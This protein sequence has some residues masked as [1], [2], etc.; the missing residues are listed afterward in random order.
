MSIGGSTA[1]Q[2]TSGTGQQTSNSRSSFAPY[3]GVQD[4]YDY[5][6]SGLTNLSQQE[7][8]YY[9]GQAYVSPSEATQYGVSGLYD[10]A[11]NQNSAL[12]TATQ[13]YNFLST[14][15]DVA[16]NPYVQGQIKANER[17][18]LDTLYENALPRLQSG[19][20]GVNNLGSSRLGLAQGQ[21]IGDTSKELANTNAAYL[22]NAYGQGLS[23]QQYAL[24]N[25]GALNEA[26]KQPAETMLQAG[27]TVEGYQQKALDDSIARYNYQYEE[28]WNRMSNVSNYLTGLFKDLGT[29]Y[30]SGTGT[31]SEDSNSNSSGFKVATK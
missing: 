2:N 21:A 27:Q 30:S 31:S 7:V 22:S 29:Q 1:S 5:F 9:P 14:A 18:V 20:V 4:I 12:K 23:A 28:P 10:A 17:S 8:P 6:A 13:N 24:G 19:A 15:A 3:S 16:N 25:T 26:Y 11:N